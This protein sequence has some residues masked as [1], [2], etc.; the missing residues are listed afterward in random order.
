MHEYFPLQVGS[1]AVRVQLAVTPGEQQRGL[2]ERRDL[3]ANDGMVFVYL[4][5]Q[6]MHFWMHNTPTPLDIGFFNAEGVLIEVYPLQPFDERTVSSRSDAIQF[7]LEM[8]QGWFAAN[9]VRP[10]AKLDLP[11]LAAALKARGFEPAQFGLP[12]GK[13]I[14]TDLKK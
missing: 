5:P 3:G 6:Q 13:P 14:E 4:K 11:A 9:G 12:A 7:P 10:G 1:K 2:M 8:N